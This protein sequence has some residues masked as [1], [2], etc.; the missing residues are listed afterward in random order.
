MGAYAKDFPQQD[1]IQA[2]AFLDSNIGNANEPIYATIEKIGR[3]LYN[4]FSNQLGNPGYHSF[5][6][7]LDEYRFFNTN[8]HE[9]LWCGHFADM[10]AFFAGQKI[11]PA[12]L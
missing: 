4:N 11:F 2:R 7:P 12:G 1:L 5:E 6:S 9:Q 8:K 3:L 10:F